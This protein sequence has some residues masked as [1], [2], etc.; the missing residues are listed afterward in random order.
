MASNEASTKGLEMSA[1]RR[2]AALLCSLSLSALAPALA[3]SALAE[4]FDIHA[5]LPLTGGAGFVGQGSQK[6]MEAAQT[7][8]N[9]AGGIHGKQVHFV[10]HDDQSS[11]QVAVQIV[12]R[13]RSEPVILGSDISAMCN[14]MAP[15]LTNGPFDYC[16]SPGIQPKPGSYQFSSLV[17][18]QDIAPAVFNF[19]RAKGWTKVALLTSTDASGQDAEHG[20][21]Q[22]LARDE[23]KSVQLVSRGHFNPTALNVSAQMSEIRSAQPEAVIA[24]ASG[25]PTA[26][27]LKGYAQ[28]G[29]SMPIVIG[30]A[31]LAKQFMMQ[32]ASILPKEFY[33]TAGLGS[34]VDG[35]LHL[36]P[37]IEAARGHYLKA[38]HAANL[39]PENA[40]EVTW[41]ATML[42]VK[43]LRELPA[44]AGAAQILENI[45]ATTDYAGVS[46]IYDFKKRPNR[47]LA[48]GEVVVA[49][50]NA[51]KQQFDAVTEPG[52]F[53][54]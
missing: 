7:V 45:S 10:F 9:D 31:N 54:K 24:W 25:A 26:T 16:F 17:P 12:D 34:V 53:L 44:G 23:N 39:T 47:G 11:P 42:V 13:L 52:G 20:F 49:K 27:L 43:A 30:Q 41:D 50:W 15:L 2:A 33:L 40:T 38:L 48:G 19:F 1:L 18:L 46:G 35:P 21:D 28:A 5:V 8:I 32:N 6:A 22:A 3:G 36:D 14:A 4:D 29:L 37:R 51:D